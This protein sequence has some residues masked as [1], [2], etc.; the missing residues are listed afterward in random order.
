MKYRRSPRFRKTA[1]GATAL[2]AVAT[3]NAP[4]AAD[5]LTDRYHEYRIDQ[6]DYR[7]AKGHWDVVEV[8]ERYRSNTVHAA[9]LHTGKVLLIAGSGSRR[10][11]FDAGGFTTL[12]WDP[13]NDSFRFVPT[14]QDLFGSGHAQLPNG[15][16]LVAGGTA[17]YEVPGGDVRRA[18]GPMLVRNDDPDRAR[19]FR[20]GTVFVGGD[21]RRYRSVRAFT[22]PAATEQHRRGRTAVSPGEGRTFVEAVR[23]GRGQAVGAPAR[24]RVVGPGGGVDGDVEGL[25]GRITMAKQ[26]YQGLRSAYE[27]DPVAERYVPVR[28]MSEARWNPTLVPLR[29]GRVLATSGLNDAGQLVAGHNE[30]YDPA[31]RRW[32]AAP[33]RSFP[34]YPALF[35]IR[36]GK[37]FYSGAN[38]GYGSTTEGRTPGVWDLRHNRFTPVP[39]L[40]APRLTETS[41]SVLLPPAQDQKVMLLGGGGVGESD[42]ATA[43]TAVA[44]LRARHP[45]FVDGPDLPLPGVRY[46]SSVIL[47][48]DRV[49]TTGGSVRYRG[50]NGSDLHKAQFYDP[51]TNTFV[52]AADPTVGRNHHSAA[53]LLPDGRVATFGSDPLFGDSR[54]SEPG[55]F[56]Q[57]IEVYSPPYL[58]RDRRPVISG[59][60]ERVRRGGSA[61][62]GVTGTRGLDRFRLVRP[63]AVTHTTDV[64]QRSVEL[65]FVR[66]RK[67]ARVTVPADPS[68]V[69][70]GWYMLF[71]VDRAGTPSEAAWIQVT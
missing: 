19:T 67:G 25:G 10:E 50:R 70:R 11:Q 6:P 48:D 8:P 20:R 32:S 65:D 17:R 54:N 23:A 52:P 18:A 49:L 28:P 40:A 60:P 57:R 3:L 59:G 56:E 55:T 61:E 46:L 38:S 44:D 53:L 27:F 26:E 15:R 62:F 5:F 30:T 36:G 9:L 37:L 29:D 4:A 31:T 58:H 1:L 64:E 35:L 63:S 39:G 42:R 2:A 16:L 41:A 13:S 24:Y 22:V 7:A 12:L 34:T 66:T 47:P 21:G 68:L 51:R 33:D 43:R 71:A 14:P 69:P 45:R